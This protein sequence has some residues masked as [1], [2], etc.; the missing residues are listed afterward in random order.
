MAPALVALAVKVTLAP[1][2]ID[3]VPVEIVTDG[4]EFGLTVIN[5]ELEVTTS[6]E[7][8]LALLV[9]STLITS[10]L[11]RVLLVYVVPPEPTLLPFFFHW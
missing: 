10:L 11:F 3:V 4:V 5:S 1:A 2:H 8:Q 9:I 6:G 7:A